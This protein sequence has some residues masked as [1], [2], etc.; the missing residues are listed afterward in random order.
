MGV[1]DFYNK[2]DL[3]AIIWH[4]IVSQTLIELGLIVFEPTEIIS[5]QTK[6]T[7]NVQKSLN[8]EESHLK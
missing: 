8:G 5:I 3:L 2:L 6:K 7:I 4:N 1:A